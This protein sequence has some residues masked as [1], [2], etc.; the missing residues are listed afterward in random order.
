MLFLFPSIPFLPKEI[1]PEY[2]PEQKVVWSLGQ[3]SA[4]ICLEDLEEGMVLQAVKNVQRQSEEIIALYRG[5]MVTPLQYTALYDTLLTKKVRLLVSPQAYEQC[6]YLPL[7][8]PYLTP[9]TPKSIWRPLEGLDM[10]SFLEEAKLVFGEA[11]LLIKDYVKSRKHEWLEACFVPS[12]SDQK[13][14]SKSIL[15]LIELQGNAINEGVVLREFVNLTPLS[16]HEKSHMPLSK[17]LRLFYFNQNRI[18][19]VSYWD[20]HSTEKENLSL[21]EFDKIAQTIPSPFF[22]MDIAEKTNGEWT[23]IEAGDGGVSGLPEEIDILSFYSSL[24]SQIR[25]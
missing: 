14:L 25:K 4:L 17:E 12:A 10:P 13:Q 2:A 20:Q 3:E 8:Y 5:W 9:H 18:A 7:V 15:K 21:E 24:L 19:T 23:I 22:T 6:H 16:R 1:D 11:P